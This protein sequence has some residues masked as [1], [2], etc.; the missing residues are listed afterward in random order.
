L[1]TGKVCFRSIASGFERGQSESIDYFFKRFS[2]QKKK[3]EKTDVK[4]HYCTGITS[5]TVVYFTSLHFAMLFRL[6]AIGLAITQI[7]SASEF[8][9]SFSFC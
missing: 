1:L 2:E 9:V 5:P 6:S 7:V 4:V 3:E 8:K